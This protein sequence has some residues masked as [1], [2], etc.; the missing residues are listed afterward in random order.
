LRAA[1]N[2]T[3]FLSYYYASSRMLLVDAISITSAYP[4]I[5]IVLSDLVL[6]EMP[7]A[8]QIMAVV[9]DF[10]GVLFIIQPTS[11][12][13]DWFGAGAALLGC[14]SFAAMAIHTHY[15][16]RTESS[17]LILLT[18]ANCILVVSLLSTPFNWHTPRSMTYC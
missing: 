17:E 13:V 10:I 6:S 5:L 4:L 15:L 11:E 18:G 16:S 2:L 3:A 14:L 1:F 9:A 7:N 12:N 8:R